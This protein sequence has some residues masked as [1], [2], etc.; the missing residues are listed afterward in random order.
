MTTVNLIVVTIRYCDDFGAANDP[1]PMHSAV[2]PIITKPAID[3]VCATEA[4]DGVIIIASFDSVSE[5]DGVLPIRILLSFIR[6]DNPIVSSIPF[7]IVCNTISSRDEVVAVTTRDVIVAIVS[8][9][10]I[11]AVIAGDNIVTRTSFDDIV[12]FVPCENISS[13]FAI[14]AI[15]SES[16]CYRVDIGSRI[17]NILAVVSFDGIIPVVAQ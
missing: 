2:D 15:V 8:V 16:T 10:R 5:K 17:N 12:P 3:D 14:D 9:K 13:Q 11:V 1:I 6:T 4:I 7:E